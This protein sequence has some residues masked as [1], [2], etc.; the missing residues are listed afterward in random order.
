MRGEGPSRPRVALERTHFLRGSLNTPRMT[1]PFP[2]LPSGVVMAFSR[3]GSGVFFDVGRRGLASGTVRSGRLLGASHRD[4]CHLPRAHRPGHRR[5]RRRQ[6]RQRRRGRRRRRGRGQRSAGA[7]FADGR[8]GD[9]LERPAVHRGPHQGR[10]NGPR[11]HA[12]RVGCRGVRRGG[13]RR[14]VCEMTRDD[15][16]WTPEFQACAEAG[17]TS[18]RPGCVAALPVGV[19][20]RAAEEQL[21]LMGEV[22]GHFRDTSATHTPPRHL[23]DS[24]QTRPRHL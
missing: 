11:P 10:A 20:G 17:C 21:V 23:R 16:R 24:S 9:A 15:P 13:V 22:A 18:L 2:A 19:V 14:D 5:R 3:A 6:R 8:L 12:P 1:H 4:L 7:T